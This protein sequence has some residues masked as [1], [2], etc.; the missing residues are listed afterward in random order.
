MQNE[1]HLKDLV[2]LICLGVVSVDGVDKQ[3]MNV[4]GE[5]TWRKFVDEK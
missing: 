5:K 3:G 4:Y 1:I 2:N